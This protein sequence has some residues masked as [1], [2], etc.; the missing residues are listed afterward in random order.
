[1]D[2]DKPMGVATYRLGAD[3]PAAYVSLIP[4]ID[5]VQQILL[6]NSEQTSDGNAQID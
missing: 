2:Y 1:M 3:I 6:E 4:V 5:G